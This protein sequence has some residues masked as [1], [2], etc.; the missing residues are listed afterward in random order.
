MKGTLFCDVYIS[1]IV[2]I[3]YCPPF[4]S[5]DKL[6][7]NKNELEELVIIALDPI[8]V[9]LTTSE[10]FS[11]PLKIGQVL[12]QWPLVPLGTNL[13]YNTRERNSLL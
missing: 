11:K 2:D 4:Y 9:Y 10:I 7:A 1:T 13:I 3:S 6:D 8:N 12:T 5:T